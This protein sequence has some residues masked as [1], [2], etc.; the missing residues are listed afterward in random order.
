MTAYPLDMSS[1][2]PGRGPSQ[3]PK[4]WRDEE[5]IEK[6]V[7]AIYENQDDLRP[8]ERTRALTLPFRSSRIWSEHEP[9]FVNVDQKLSLHEA[10][11]IYC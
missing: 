3:D 7:Q 11:Q 10:S 4:E 9:S 8:I 6:D 1:Q 5:V 2:N